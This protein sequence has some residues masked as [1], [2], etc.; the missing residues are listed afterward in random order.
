MR[1]NLKLSVGVVPWLSLSG[2][3]AAMSQTKS[4]EAQSGPDAIE[5]RFGEVDGSRFTT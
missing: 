3:V 2:S 1:A 4:S 5:S